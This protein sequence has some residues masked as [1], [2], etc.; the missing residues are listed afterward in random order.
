MDTNTVNKK[1]TFESQFMEKLSNTETELKK[2]LLK[3]SVYLF[4]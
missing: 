1:A 2:A 3:K 4:Q